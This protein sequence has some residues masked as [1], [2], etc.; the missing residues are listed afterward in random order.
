MIE[1][2]GASLVE[3][4]S[5]LSLDF[6]HD[7]ISFIR[8]ADLEKIEIDELKSV[9][10]EILKAYGTYVKSIG[11]GE[12]M[13]RVMKHQPNEKLFENVSRIYPDPTF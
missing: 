2:D 11:Q 6:I 3:L 4:L 7:R 13:F 1:D 10:A 5:K 9:L 8:Q 12:P